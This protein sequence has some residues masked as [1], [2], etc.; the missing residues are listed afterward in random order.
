MVQADLF[1]DTG[2]TI[3]E[4]AALQGTPAIIVNAFRKQHVN[5]FLARKG[6][7]IF[8]TQPSKVPRLAEKLLGKKKDVKPLLARLENPVDV[9]ANIVDKLA[10]KEQDN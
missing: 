9:I 10:K 3:I 5:D 7:P 8:R 4:E 1:V 6:F 2:G